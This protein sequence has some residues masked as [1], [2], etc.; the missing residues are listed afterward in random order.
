MFGSAARGELGP[1]S[2]IDFLY[3]F[4]P[5]QSM[6]WEIVNAIEELKILTGRD[7]DFVSFDAILQS[8]NQYSKSDI[9]RDARLIYPHAA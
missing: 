9:L 7:V 1:E 4:E 8:R 5:N 6:G 3:R 2:D